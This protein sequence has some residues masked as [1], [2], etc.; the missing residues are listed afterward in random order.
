MEVVTNHVISF[1]RIGLETI[2]FIKELCVASHKTKRNIKCV[3]ISNVSNI[4]D[5]LKK[6]DLGFQPSCRSKL[7]RQ[8][9]VI[10]RL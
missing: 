6:P 1:G 4:S 9:L 5:T 7:S 3:A 8:K 10:L 2:P